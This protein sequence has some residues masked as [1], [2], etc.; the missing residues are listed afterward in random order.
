MHVKVRDAGYHP[1]PFLGIPFRNNDNLG[2][3]LQ[4]P[5]PLASQVRSITQNTECVPDVPWSDLTLRRNRLE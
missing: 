3:I 4:C 5:F 2:W 1:L